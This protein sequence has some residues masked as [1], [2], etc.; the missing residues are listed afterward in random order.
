M[1]ILH[2]P[3]LKTAQNQLRLKDFKQLPLH[4]HLKAFLINWKLASG[5]PNCFLV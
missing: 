1:A 4:W 3:T 2:F 5:T